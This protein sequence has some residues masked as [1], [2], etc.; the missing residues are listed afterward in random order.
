[1]LNENMLDVISQQRQD[2]TTYLQNVNKRKSM[3]SPHWI[4]KFD[5]L[6]F[7]FSRKI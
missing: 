5:I 1:M 7:T 4:L 6:L 2:I 3:T